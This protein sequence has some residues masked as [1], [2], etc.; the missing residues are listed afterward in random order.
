MT[1]FFKVL[2]SAP[3]AHSPISSRPFLA[4]GV[5]AVQHDINRPA[6]CTLTDVPNLHVL[7]LVKSLLSRKLVK[8]QFNWGWGYYT[9]TNEGIAY[10]KQYLST[11]NGVLGEDVVP[12]THVAAKQARPASRPLS[13]EDRPP[14]GPGGFDRGP[15]QD[16]PPREGGEGGGYRG[17][18]K[19]EG[20]AGPGFGGAG[21]FQGGG[22][23]YPPRTG[24]PRPAPGQ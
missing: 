11:I 18:F 23:G 7:W 22:R 4:E 24:A 10:L 9:L 15:R 20:T 5:I 14:R 1:L 21:M 6:H 3:S 16:R 2:P 19:K 17:G 12:K 8:E 13:G